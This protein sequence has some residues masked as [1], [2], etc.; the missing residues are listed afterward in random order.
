MSHRFRY[1]TG[2]VLTTFRVTKILR[3]HKT[4]CKQITCSKGDSTDAVGYMS[5]NNRDKVNNFYI[6]K[7]KLYY[8]ID[9]IESEVHFV[10]LKSHNISNDVL[11]LVRNK[12]QFYQGPSSHSNRRETFHL[13]GITDVR[14]HKQFFFPPPRRITRQ[15]ILPKCF[16]LFP[17][18]QS[19][20]LL[21]SVHS[22]TLSISL[23]HSL[24]FPQLLKGCQ[25]SSHR[26][27]DHNS[28]MGG[29]G[30]RHTTFYTEK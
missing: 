6:Q 5:S 14:N 20:C 17:A 30:G 1:F 29:G 7:K 4:H 9:I 25:I 3:F 18:L 24:Y 12:N 22:L 13:L 26:I 11:S 27:R 15:R 8:I 10:A 23:S 28:Y 21:T 16:P 19:V 2:E